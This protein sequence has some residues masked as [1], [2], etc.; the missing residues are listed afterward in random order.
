MRGQFAIK[1]DRPAVGRLIYLASPNAG[2]GG[3]NPDVKVFYDQ[4]R[5]RGKPGKA[6]FGAVMRKLIALANTLVADNREWSPKP[7]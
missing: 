5:A 1:G 6:A 4:P 3:A 2:T 7:A